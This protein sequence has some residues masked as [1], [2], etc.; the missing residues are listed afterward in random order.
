MSKLQANP[1]KAWKSMVNSD[2]DNAKL[3]KDFDSSNVK[4]V[5]TDEHIEFS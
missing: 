4:Q 1:S 3:S 5:R 2:K